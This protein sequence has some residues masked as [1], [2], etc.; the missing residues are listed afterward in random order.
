MTRVGWALALAFVVWVPGRARG[1]TYGTLGLLERQSVDLA[2]ASRGLEIDPA[3]AGKVVGKIHVVNQAVFS[4]RDLFLSFFNHF[5]RT[6]REDVVAREVL[7]R[8]GDVW[9]DD[10]VDESLRNLRDP[11]LSNVVV[12]LPVKSAEP[13]KVDLLVVT[14][15][16]WS[17][18]LNSRFEVQGTALTFLSASVAENNLFGWRKKLSLVFTMDQGAIALGPTYIDGNIHGS[19]LTLTSS[20]RTLFSRATGDFEGTS[21]ST[22]IAYPLWSLRRKWGLGL[23]VAHFDGVVRFFRGTSLR[24]YDIPETAAVESFPRV[25]DLRQLQTELSAVRSI[26][27]RVVSRVFFGHEL[28]V[29]R[30]G[31]R[32]DFTGDGGERAAFE[33]DVLPRSERSSALFVRYRMLTPRYQPFRDLDTFDLREDVLTGPEL[34]VKVSAAMRAIGS[35]N[36]FV[37]FGG[38]AAYTLAHRWYGLLRGSAGWS[39]RVDGGEVI[40]NLVSTKVSAASGMLG[41]F[42]RVVAQVATDKLYRDRRNSFLTLGGDSGLRGYGI[43]AFSGQSR[44]VGHLEARTIPL[45]IGPTRWGLA[46]FWDAGH[47][48]DRW[49]DIS[50]KHDVGVGLRQL[51]PQLNPFVLR[52]DWAFALN[53]S[54]AGWP[55]RFSLAFMQAF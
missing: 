15:D 53:G 25:Y 7:L 20:L 34:D 11:F 43:A 39:A 48:A 49:A 47:A 40:D 14:R 12:L 2:L 21:G 5:H 28:D 30:P 50:P 32:G 24:T 37:R 8:P 46:G 6:T 44:V 3:P 33:R 4:K 22:G 26:G 9:Q 38:V 23:E 41:C 10:I 42:V 55:G 16:V 54:G 35:E 45:K 1:D 29:Q 18:R 27:S 51:T 52:A 17:L 31:V 13:G 36:D 19:R